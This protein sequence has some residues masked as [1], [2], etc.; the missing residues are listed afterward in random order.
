MWE[1][2]EFLYPVM[3]L[4]AVHLKK[5]KQKCNILAKNGVFLLFC[6]FVHLNCDNNMKK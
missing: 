3:F 6:I 4:E 5:I 2:Q 1:I